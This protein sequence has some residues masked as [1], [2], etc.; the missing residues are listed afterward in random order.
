MLNGKDQ[1]HVTQFTFSNDGT[2]IINP[3]GWYRIG[4][5]MEIS[6]A[7]NGNMCLLFLERGYN[8]IE[9]E[10]YA[11]IINVGYSGRV[12]ITQLSGSRLTR[13]G[14]P[15][16][17]VCWKSDKKSYIDCFLN[18]PN[19]EWYGVTI[20]GGFK[21]LSFNKVTDTDEVNNVAEFATQNGFKATILNN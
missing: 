17:R 3:N 18:H 14:I 16:I 20:F 7:S 5:S 13:Y 1:R 19:Q 8:Y 10:R 6:S 2:N 4:E 9:P 12:D 15:K 11:F 21:S